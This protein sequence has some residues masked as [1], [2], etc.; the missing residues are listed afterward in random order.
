MYFRPN[1]AVVYS[2]L[3]EEYLRLYHHGGGDGGGE[4]KKKT[5]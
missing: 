4:K 1:A 5:V 2:G 3:R